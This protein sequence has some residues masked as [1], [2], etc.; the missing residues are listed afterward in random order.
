MSPHHAMG[1]GQGL[2][3]LEELG[4]SLRT[5]QSQRDQTGDDALRALLDEQLSAVRKRLR[6]LQHRLQSR[7]RGLGSSSSLLTPDADPHTPPG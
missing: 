2:R 3:E 1:E 6:S 7:R 4:L 5:L